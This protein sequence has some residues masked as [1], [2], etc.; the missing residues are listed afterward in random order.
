LLQIPPLQPR[1]QTWL[2]TLLPTLLPPRLQ[3][4]SSP[5]ASNPLHPCFNAKG[6]PLGRLVVASRP[7]RTHTKSLFPIGSPILPG[8]SLKQGLKLAWSDT[9][10]EARW[11]GR[12]RRGGSEARGGGQSAADGSGRQN[13]CSAQAGVKQRSSMPSSQA[14]SSSDPW[15]V[16]LG[17]SSESCGEQ[18]ALQVPS[19]AVKRGRPVGSRGNAALRARLAVRREEPQC[20]HLAD[21]PHRGMSSPA[22][23]DVHGHIG[24][25]CC[26]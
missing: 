3:S 26:V 12:G 14:S 9:R 7:T 24:P 6:N 5:L 1:H 23:P 16:S 13:T 2:Q 11:S 10:F 4:S 15:E 22:M 17:E 19:T 21:Y 20:E 8:E 25:K 18:V